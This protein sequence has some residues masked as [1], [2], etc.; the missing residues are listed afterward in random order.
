MHSSKPQQVR[1]RDFDSELYDGRCRPSF[2]FV[3]WIGKTIE[4]MGATHIMDTIRYPDD[5]PSESLLLSKNAHEN[6]AKA[7][8]DALQICTYVKTM[9]IN[10]TMASIAVIRNLKQQRWFKLILK[11]LNLQ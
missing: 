7:G 4:A 10:F 11:R 3:K 5:L 8:S 1:R 2:P 6:R 9:T